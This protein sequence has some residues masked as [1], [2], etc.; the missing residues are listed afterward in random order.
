MAVCASEVRTGK[1]HVEQPCIQEEK[2]MVGTTTAFMVVETLRRFIVRSLASEVSLTTALIAAAFNLVFM[3]NGASS[4]CRQRKA[5]KKG[6][7]KAQ[8]VFHL[9]FGE[10][11]SVFLR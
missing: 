5:S 8:L 10:C 3:A 2:P 11:S 1:P 9:G 7:Q 4:V 6:S